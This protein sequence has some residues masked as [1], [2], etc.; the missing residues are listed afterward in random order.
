MRVRRYQAT[1]RFRMSAERFGRSLLSATFVLAGLNHLFRPRLYRA[2]MPPYLPAHNALV[3]ISGYAEIVLGALVLIP[4]ARRAA[5]VGLIALLVAVFPANIHM[6]LHAH[7]YPRIPRWLLW[8]RLPFQ[9]VFAAWV[10][11]CALSQKSR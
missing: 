9:G 4:R 5:G 7:R 6:A 8:L 2:I 3:A 10:Y 1:T 11:W